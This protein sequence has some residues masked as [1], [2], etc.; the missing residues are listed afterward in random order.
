MAAAVICHPDK[1]DFE[2]SHDAVACAEAAIFWGLGYISYYDVVVSIFF[3]IIPIESLYNI[4]RPY[5]H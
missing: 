1:F 2:T 3:S 4:K 5:G